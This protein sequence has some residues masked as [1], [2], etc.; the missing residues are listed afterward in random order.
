MVFGSMR[1]AVQHL[2]QSAKFAATRRSTASTSASCV[3]TSHLSSAFVQTR[4]SATPVAIQPQHVKA[5]PTGV[6]AGIAIV[7]ALIGVGKMWWD[8][9]H[10]LSEETEVVAFQEIPQAEIALFF[11]D[12]TAAV[13]D[14]FS[15]LPEIENAVRKYLKENNHE[16]SDAEF[17]QS[18]LSQ[19]YQMMEELEKQIVGKRRWSRQ[20]LEFALEKYA[21]DEEILKLQE[22]LNNLMQTC[23]GR[24]KLTSSLDASVFPAPIPVEIP[25]DL[26]ADKT[27]AIL[28]EMVAGME[29]AMSDM[30]AHARTEGINDVREAMEEFQNLYMEHVEQAT[31]KQMNA[32]GISQEVFAAALQKYNTEDEQFRQQVEQIYTQ[33]AK[34][35]QKM[36]LPVETQ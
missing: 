31:Q 8:S 35:F 11:T 33:Q 17:Q 9:S 4:V 23:C 34:A 18:I 16:L 13:N 7:G 30:L 28:K 1:H 21:Q 15:Q 12:L 6:V 19:L 5:D 27:L 25:E 10:S 32:H 24:R 2:R 29:K 22:A 26:T 36:G 20:S 3:N 14:L